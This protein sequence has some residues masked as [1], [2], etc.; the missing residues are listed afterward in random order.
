MTDARR[1]EYTARIGTR[2]QVR[3]LAELV[4]WLSVETAHVCAQYYPVGLSDEVRVHTQAGKLPRVVLSSRRE[5]VLMSA[6]QVSARI[7]V[8]QSPVRVPWTIRIV[9]DHD[10][11]P[12]WSAPATVHLDLTCSGVGGGQPAW[13]GTPEMITCIPPAVPVDA[14]MYAIAIDLSERLP[15]VFRAET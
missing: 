9:E 2:L 10:I 8:Q 15:V 6:Q 13:H 11:A 5:L 14:A 3:P 1:A 7:G 12:R 4:R